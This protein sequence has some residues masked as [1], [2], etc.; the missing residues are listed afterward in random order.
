MFY[1]KENA[2]SNTTLNIKSNINYNFPLHLH[3][4]YEFI[5]ITSGEMNVRIEDQTFT[6]HRGQ[7]VFIFPNQVHSLE[8][9]V[10]SSHTL[11]IFSPSHI[12]AYASQ[13]QNLVPQNNL[14][15]VPSFL[16]ELLL[17]LKSSDSHFK[18]KG[19]LYLLCCEIDKVANYRKRTPEQDS[20][21]LRIFRFVEENYTSDC[22][23]KFLSEAVSY[24]PVYLSRYF[25]ERV[26]FPFTEYVN[27]LRV[28]ES[29]YRL[30]NTPQSITDIALECGFDSMRTFHRNFKKL[31]GM[32]PVEYR[33]QN[34][35]QGREKAQ[36]NAPEE[37]RHP[38]QRAEKS[39]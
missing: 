13:C 3:E 6:A 33:K 4:S 21:L 30:I 11:W 38:G 18:I 20:L 34:Y 27:R 2:A 5:L 25:K 17:D 36:Y 32:T 9:K 28:D 31:I 10:S 24:H 1:E 23:I 16:Q 19:T 12:K 39:Q 37:I 15:D 29:C 35:L 14:I 7:G 26:G 22:S 8:T